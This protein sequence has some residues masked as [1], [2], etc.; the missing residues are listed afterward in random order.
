MT[1]QAAKLLDR[2]DDIHN[3]L[4]DLTQQERRALEQ[5]A[6]VKQLAQRQEIARVSEPVDGLYLVIDGK[7]RVESLSN[8]G[9][10]F[11]V[12]TLPSG[13]F[14]GLISVLDEQPSLHSAWA[15]TETTSVV[16]PPQTVR[17]LVRRNAAVNAKVI[18][19]LCKRS[20]MSFAINDRFALAGSSQR[21]AQGL[22]SIAE[23][24]H[25]LDAK[26][27]PEGIIKI[28]QH[29][30]SSMLALSRMSVNRTLKDLEN[31]GLLTLGY[32]RVR[33]NDFAGLRCFVQ[34]ESRSLR[35]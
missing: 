25:S 7:I 18:Q 14:H 15:L 3:L 21:V 26:A 20:R 35:L 8:D 24:K 33:I 23:G 2:F 30:L 9:K 16:F 6:I 10:Y 4:S 31:R 27:S 19:C 11:S 32:N 22:L 5:V 17:D 29:E 1:T 34:G 12:G 13:D 28:S